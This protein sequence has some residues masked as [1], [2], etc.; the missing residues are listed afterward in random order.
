MQLTGVTEHVLKSNT[1]FLVVNLKG[2][3]KIISAVSIVKGHEK[4]PLANGEHAFTTRPFLCQ[5]AYHLSRSALMLVQAAG[6]GASA[7]AAGVSESDMSVLLGGDLGACPVLSM[8]VDSRAQGERER[9][10]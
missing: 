2:T 5:G 10:R 4:R 7:G 3:W 1:R 6:T 9:E 8:P